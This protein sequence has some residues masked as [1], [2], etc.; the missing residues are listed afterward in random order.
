MAEGAQ[1]TAEVLIGPNSKL[2][3]SKLHATKLSPTAFGWGFFLA[4]SPS[5]HQPW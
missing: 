1:I 4:H 5:G 3:G 2:F